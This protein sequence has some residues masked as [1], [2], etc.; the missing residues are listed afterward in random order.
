VEFLRFT[1]VSLPTFPSGSI[2]GFVFSLTCELLGWFGEN[3]MIIID[4]LVFVFE[5]AE[6]NLVMPTLQLACE[7]AERGAR[8]GSLEVYRLFVQGFKM[9]KVQ[10]ELEKLVGKGEESIARMAQQVIDFTSSAF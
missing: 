9:G 10:S 4:V 6:L 8:E 2:I 3:V 1:T 5:T 7:I